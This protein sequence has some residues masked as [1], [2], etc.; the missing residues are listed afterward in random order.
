[1]PAS[2]ARPSA[3][4]ATTMTGVVSARS[5]R[6]ISSSSGVRPSRASIRNKAASASRTAASVCWRIRPGQRLRVFVLEAGGVD[7]PEFE[8]EQAR[9]A[10]APVA[11][12]AR[13]V[14]DQRQALADEPVEQGRFADVGPAD[15]GDGGEGHG[16]SR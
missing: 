15:D 16:A 12:Y 8:P 6:P 3:L 14:V 1:M 5:Q 7:H 9:L 10:L 13:P 2:P 11:G 4:L